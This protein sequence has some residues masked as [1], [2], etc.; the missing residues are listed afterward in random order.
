MAS[1]L[2][3][4]CNGSGTDDVA[5]VLA[6]AVPSLD[7]TPG[8]CPT[9]AGTGRPG[10]VLFDGPGG[11]CIRPDQMEAFRCRSVD[12][13]VLA[14]AGL[15]FL[16][17]RFAAPVP[18]LP[19]EARV[20]GRSA[21]TVVF[22]VPGHLPRVFVRTGT[23]LERWLAVPRLPRS[24]SPRA[25]F[26][27]DSIMVASRPEVTQ[28]LPDWTREFNS[29]VGR[30]M[31][32]GIRVA[33]RLPLDGVD[34]AVIELGTNQS[35]ADGFPTLA[36][37]LLSIV[38]D[39]PLVVWVTVHRDLDFVS[40]INADIGR[41]AGEAPNAVVADWNQAVPS[42]GL[43][44]DGIHPTDVGKQVMATLLSGPLERWHLAATGRGDTACAPSV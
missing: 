19:A 13:P 27:G 9:S 38:R 4:A 25:L 2:L 35:T 5:D 39:V 43:L 17:G 11:G 36:R 28:A 22:V 37:R 44:S 6:S 41:A 18:T 23:R 15:R 21:S 42:D 31:S 29:R 10:I 1:I 3:C 30:G 16:G 8:P 7:T 40:E 26:L 33:S 24:A 12:D 20:L 32:E 14:I 34:A